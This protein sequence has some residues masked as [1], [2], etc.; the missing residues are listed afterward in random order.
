MEVF[1]DLFRIKKFREDK[2]ELNLVKEKKNL[3]VVIEEREQAQ[4]KLMDYKE[5]RKKQEDQI[6]KNLYSRL[7]KIKDINEVSEDVKIMQ[8]EVE[9]LNE[10]L[11]Q[12]HEKFNNAKAAVEQAKKLHQEAIRMREKYAEA[13]KINETDELA[14]LQLL[15]E[16]GMEETIIIPNIQNEFSKSNLD[17]LY[18]QMS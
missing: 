17:N 1:N 16:L 7:V 10:V 12:M 2:A 15:E 8:D 13:I 14:E 11:N 6:Y 9:R 5:Y 18:G 3:N 4:K